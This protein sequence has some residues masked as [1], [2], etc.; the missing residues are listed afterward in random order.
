MVPNFLLWLRVRDRRGEGKAPLRLFQGLEVFCRSRIQAKRD[1]KGCG[2]VGGL[3]FFANAFELVA[4]HRF[5]MGRGEE[6]SRVAV[7]V[8]WHGNVEVR[9]SVSP[10]HAR[11]IG[12]RVFI[13]EVVGGK[14][15]FLLRV[16]EGKL[17]GFGKGIDVGYRRL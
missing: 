5:L 15:A 2:F 8:H 6:E 14:A 16:G 1:R 10:R 17:Q 12:E 7:R 11:C 13:A 4:G 3:W 9:V